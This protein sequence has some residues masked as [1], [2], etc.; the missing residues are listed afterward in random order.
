MKKMISL[1]LVVALLSSLP[2][3][4]AEFDLSD[5]SFMEDATDQELIDLRDLIDE[6]LKERKREA[7]GDEIEATRDNPALIGETV[8]YKEDDYLGS[9]EYSMRVECAAADSAASAILKSF[10]RYNSSRLN[11]GEKWV[12]VQLHIE[13]LA[14]DNDKVDLN[15]Y[16]VAFVSQDGVEYERAYISDNPAEIKALYVGSEQVAW[17]AAVVKTDDT[18]MLTYK[19][20]GGQD[21]VWFSLMERAPF[22]G[23]EITAEVLDKNSEGEEVTFLQRLLVEMGYLTAAPNGAYDKAT[24]SAVKSFQKTNSLKQSGTVDADTKDCL[25]SGEALAKP[26]SKK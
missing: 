24:I 11:K 10:N 26:V 25:L 18:P 8:F 5:L 22:T 1:L 3:A 13:A 20:S 21:T 23:D 15:E 7:A 16:N 19:T 6:E 4:L 9:S 12:L 14:S 2:F 17:V